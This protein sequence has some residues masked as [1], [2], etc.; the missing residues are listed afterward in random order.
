MIESNEEPAPSPAH[1]FER[2]FG[3]SLFVPWS[4]VLLE[5]AEPG[6]DDRVLDLACATGIVARRVAPLVDEGEGRVVGVDLDPD[7]LAVAR[8]LGAAEEDVDV[9]WRQGDA[10]DLDLPDGSFDL[11][12]CQ[13]GLQFFDD[14]G[15]AV[16]ETDRVLDDGGRL[17][18]N[19]WQPL[20]RHPVYRALLEA[21]AR[22][23]DAELEAVARPFVFGDAR[24]LH[25]LFDG[26]GF[27]DVEVMEETRDVVFDDPETFVALTVMAGAAV[28][29]ELSPDD[30]HARDELIEAIREDC[31]DVLEAHTEGDTL[32]FPTP[33][34]I[35][36]ARL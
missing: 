36:T 5:H 17:V 12:L 15:A 19:V 27:S 18:A 11:V 7:M 30:P 28:V 14:P 6:P 31:A 21:E 20:D 32:R 13:Q 9:T 4:R 24:R 26:T 29:P 22:H 35:V 1:L 8:E 23:L 16:R 2:F 3:P 10:T 25:D 34:Y 33:N